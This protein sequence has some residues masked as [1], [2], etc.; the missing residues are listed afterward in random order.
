M[1]CAI[2]EIGQGFLLWNLNPYPSSQKVLSHSVLA[3]ISPL[4][5]WLLWFFRLY[6]SFACSGISCEWNH[7]DPVIGLGPLSSPTLS[8]L[9]GCSVLGSASIW[10]PRLFS[11]NRKAHS[12][13][14]S[15]ILVTKQQF[16]SVSYILSLNVVKV[17]DLWIKFFTLTFPRCLLGPSLPVFMLSNE[18][19]Q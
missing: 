12:W 8:L 2:S 4:E 10:R 3:P 6:V 19:L 16:C 11:R 5:D 14:Q 18:S 9:A 1:K 15:N 17:N 7:A 13:M